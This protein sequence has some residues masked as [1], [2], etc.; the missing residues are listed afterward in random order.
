[1][2]K[3]KNIL[4]KTIVKMTMCADRSLF[5]ELLVGES[6]EVVR[7]ESRIC[8]SSSLN[9]CV[10]VV[11]FTDFMNC[12]TDFLENKLTTSLQACTPSTHVYSVLELRLVPQ[13]SNQAPPG[14][15]QLS[16]SDFLMAAHLW[17]T[18][19]ILVAVTVGVDITNISNKHRRLP[20][21]QTLLGLHK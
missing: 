20:L 10:A 16:L 13:F 9:C 18:G 6:Y 5:A 7:V 15:Q 21:H 19:V 3:L 2:F 17:H 8:L 12:D 14:A 11:W 1:M 4:N